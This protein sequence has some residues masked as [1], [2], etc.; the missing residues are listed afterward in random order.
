MPRIDAMA[1]EHPNQLLTIAIHDSADAVAR[2]TRDRH[3]VFPVD[4]RYLPQSN[5]TWEEDAREFLPT[6]R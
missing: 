2:Y 3:Y 6:R 4:G 5:E 1:R